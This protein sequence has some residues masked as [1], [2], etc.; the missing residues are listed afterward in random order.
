MDAVS[1]TQAMIRFSLSRS[2]FVKLTLLDVAGREVATLMSGELPRG[3]YT[4]QWD[5]S[6]YRGGVYSCRLKAGSELNLC[7]RVSL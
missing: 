5:A 4:F 2:E 7:R 1:Y 3:N 6:K